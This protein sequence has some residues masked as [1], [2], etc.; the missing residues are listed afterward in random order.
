MYKF[1]NEVDETNK[2]RVID[3]VKKHFSLSN[4]SNE[5]FAD[6]LNNPFID[7]VFNDLDNGLRKRMPLNNKDLEN[8]DF[9]WAKFKK[10]FPTLEKETK[11]A[12]EDFNNNFVVYKKN[13]IRILKR[14][15]LFYT[16]E[17]GYKRRLRDLCSYHGWTFDGTFSKE[18]ISDV[19]YLIKEK[20]LQSAKNKLPKDNLELVIT[21]NFADI[22]LSATGDSWR[23]CL[24]FTSE[25]EGAYWAGLPGLA[26][27]KNRFMVYI[28]NGEKKIFEGIKVDKMFYRSFG[29]I[30]NENKLFTVKW[31]PTKPIEQK[32]FDL[33]SLRNNSDAFYKSKH[34]FDLLKYVNDISCYIFQD[35][36]T[37]SKCSFN[38]VH[39][40]VGEKGMKTVTSH[41]MHYG[42]IHHIR[43]SEG[44]YTLTE[45]NRK[46]DDFSIFGMSQCNDCGY[47]GLEDEMVYDNDGAA[48]C[49]NCYNQR[50]V[51]CHGCGGTIRRRYSYT[52][53][54]ENYCEDCYQGLVEERRDNDNNDEIERS[55]SELDRLLMNGNEARNMW[56]QAS[57][58]VSGNWYAATAATTTG[59]PLTYN[60]EYVTDNDNND[61]EEVI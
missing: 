32:G 33:L 48:Y 27:D 3:L 39:L 23:S 56:T 40:V 19:I 46:L 18:F 8:L 17:E 22:F 43:E 24:S 54:S 29:I 42:T 50:Y 1:D 61:N 6:A 10:D 35:N 47:R 25:W 5:R 52:F 41:G 45:G 34:S 59:G 14:L 26:V 44:L 9:N 58:D 57:Q 55:M 31:Y 51:T 20:F 30:D 60:I 2:K 7:S 53:N 16:K 15:K 36:T 37:F 13:K 4:D 49:Q 38:N 28:T 12:Y 21:L 11:I